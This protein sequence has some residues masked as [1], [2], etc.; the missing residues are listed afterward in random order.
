MNKNY[1]LISAL[2]LIS[3]G[4]GHTAPNKAQLAVWANEAIVATYTFDYKN[5]LAE[6]KQIAKYFS[7]PG[8]ITYSQALIDS[9]L[10]ENVQKNSYFVSAVATQ[11][12]VI[13]EIDATH[14]Q[15]TMPILVLYENPQYKQQQHLH[16]VLNFSEAAPDQGIR[17]LRIDSLQS[18]ASAPPCQCV[19]QTIDSIANT[20]EKQ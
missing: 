15:A 20:D 5:Y 6:Q 14:W 17:G 10:P 19:N 1:L 3:I 12:P 16:V 13:K 8:W 2:W 9:K 18:T 7:S 4:E 11:P